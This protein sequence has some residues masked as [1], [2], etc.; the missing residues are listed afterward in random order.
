MRDSKARRA[1]R[2]GGQVES[3]PEKK[4]SWKSCKSCLRIKKKKRPGI[5][6]WNSSDSIWHRTWKSKGYRFWW[7]CKQKTSKPFTE[8]TNQPINHFLI[9]GMQFTYVWKSFLTF[10]LLRCS[11]NYPGCGEYR[12]AEFNCHKKLLNINEIQ[13]I[14]LSFRH[15]LSMRSDFNLT[16]M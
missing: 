2:D 4:W 14:P 12:R 13:L 8:S 16:G 11:L 10:F 3:D 6:M 15:L 7:R 9:C 5:L 1:G